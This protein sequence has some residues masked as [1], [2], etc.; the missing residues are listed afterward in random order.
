MT[1]NIQGVNANYQLLNGY[2]SIPVKAGRIPFHSSKRTGL[3]HWPGRQQVV[4]IY[5]PSSQ[6]QF[7][8]NIAA[9]D[10]HGLERNVHQIGDFLAGMAFLNKLAHSDFRACQ[11]QKPSIQFSGKS[12]GQMD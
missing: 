11:F 3:K 5:F 9:M 2:K 6:T 10:L 12:F 1:Q 8:P 7:F 4:Q